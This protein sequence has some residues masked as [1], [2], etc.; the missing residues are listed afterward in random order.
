MTY[1]R[2]T[3]SRRL[4][5]YD[6]EGSSSSSS[7]HLN[8]NLNCTHQKQ[9]YK[10]ICTHLPGDIITYFSEMVKKAV[11]VSW[12]FVAQPA[13]FIDTSADYE[14]GVLFPLNW[15]DRALFSERVLMNKEYQAFA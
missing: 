1:N 7:R 13:I 14:V 11:L 8:Y 3:R 9:K 4:L 5:C 2:G 12:L 6:R 10:K 15:D